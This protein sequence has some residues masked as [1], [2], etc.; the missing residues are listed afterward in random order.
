MATISRW[1]IW[2]T[3]DGR[4]EDW[5]QPASQAQ[6]TTC[7]TDT[8]HAIDAGKTYRTQEDVSESGRT[9]ADGALAIKVDAGTATSDPKFE[10]TH[11][12]VPAAAGVHTVLVP[13]VA[14]G[15]R[16]QGLDYHVEEPAYGDQLDVVF[17]SDGTFVHPTLGALPQ[18]ADL[19]AFGPRCVP[20]V[21]TATAGGT[22]ARDQV[23]F[24]TSKLIPAGVQ[25]ALRYTRAAAVAQPTRLC[26]DWLLH[27]EP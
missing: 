22:W 27:V 24:D 8:A 3:V 1:R 20:L 5:W 15:K 13:L 19:Q 26:V 18:G 6:P 11:W 2:C 14:P 23:M 4:W 25:V 16:L 17:Q 21:T 7:P 12:A 10:V 9:T